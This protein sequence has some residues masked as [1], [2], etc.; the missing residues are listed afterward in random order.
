MQT[1]LAMALERDPQMMKFFLERALPKETPIHL[2]LPR[3]RTASDAKEALA[4][5]AQAVAEG[6]ISPSQGAAVSSIADR[7]IRAVEVTE[8]SDRVSRFFSGRTDAAGH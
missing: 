6:K 2:E 4:I 3:L 1:G 8:L 7:F 5:I